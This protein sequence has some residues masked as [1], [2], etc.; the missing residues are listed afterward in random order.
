MIPQKSIVRFHGVVFFFF[1]L[2][3]IHFKQARG[4]CAFLP[5]SSPAA[6]AP[7]QAAKQGY[8]FL[9]LATAMSSM[10][11]QARGSISANSVLHR[12]DEGRVLTQHGHY[13]CH[14]HG[15]R[16]GAPLSIVDSPYDTTKTWARPS[17]TTAGPQARQNQPWNRM[18]SQSQCIKSETRSHKKS[19]E[20]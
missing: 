17:G 14:Q 5:V 3:Q 19:R 20:P 6:S 13:R 1:F 16:P 2:Q 7:G 15:V 11:N 9:P 18:A 4:T 12:G 10:A 8:G